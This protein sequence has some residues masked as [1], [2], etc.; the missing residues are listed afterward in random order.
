MRKPCESSKEKGGKDGGGQCVAQIAA[1]AEACSALE[2]PQAHL[3]D[4]RKAQERVAALEA[5]SEFVPLA[6]MVYEP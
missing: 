2:E 5:L 6:G 1:P 3:A 4:L